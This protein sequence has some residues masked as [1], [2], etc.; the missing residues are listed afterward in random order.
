MAQQID[1]TRRTSTAAIAVDEIWACP[2]IATTVSHPHQ[3]DKCAST[4]ER[5]HDVR[6]KGN[7]KLT[8]RI[9]A[10]LPP[11]VTHPIRD[12]QVYTYSIRRDDCNDI[13][14]RIYDDSICNAC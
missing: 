6:T 14:R 11:S 5:D 13:S 12:S 9:N 1:P 8:S 7:I 3:H 4:G 10:L 2:P